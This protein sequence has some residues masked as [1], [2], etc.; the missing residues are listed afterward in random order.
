MARNEDFSNGFWDHPDIEPLSADATLLFIWSWTNP[1]CG[2]AGIYEVGRRAMMEC[3]VPDER[4][5]ATLEELAS[6]DKALYER[7]VL[8][9]LKRTAR[10]R[11]KSI[12]V[13]K[14]AVKDL[15]QVPEGHPLRDL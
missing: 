11:T 9:V 15:L 2:M 1:R 14:S 3:K 8:F 7:G 13:A 12:Q 4:L 10:V 6:Y 5:D